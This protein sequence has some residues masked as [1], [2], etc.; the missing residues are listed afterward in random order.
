MIL[1][2]FKTKNKVY[3]AV[4]ELIENEY[5]AR[6]TTKEV[7]WINHNIFYKGNYLITKEL[8][9]RKT[10]EYLKELGIR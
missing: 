5:I 8:K 9:I 3:I 10:E 7:Y 4:N 1:I 2:K 6:T